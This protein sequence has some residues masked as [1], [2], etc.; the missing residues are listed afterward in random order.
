MEGAD[1]EWI[2]S[3]VAH[4]AQNM[5]AQD[6]A[7]VAAMHPGE[8]PYSILALSVS[9]STCG[10][11][12]PAGD[13]PVAIFGAAP[14]ALPEIGCVWLLGTDKLV[15]QAHS[16]ARQTPFYIDQMLAHHPGLFNHIDS[17]NTVSVWWLKWGGFTLLGDHRAPS[18][19]LFHTFAKSRD[20]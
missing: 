18:G 3:S 17:R 14:T 8:D 19:H 11:I 20:P 10:W 7:E 2:A 12:I 1:P 15:R 4:V 9:L 5:R 13:E 16:F 6:V